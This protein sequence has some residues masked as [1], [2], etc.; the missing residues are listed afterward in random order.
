MPL[1]QEIANISD[2]SGVSVGVVDLTG[3]AF[4]NAGYRDRL[5]EARPDENTIYGMASLSKSFASGLMGLL[6]EENR[7]QFDTPIK[8]VLPGFQRGERDPAINTTIEDLLSHRS[9]LPG[10][11]GY[12]LLSRNVVAFKRH[13]VLPI[14][15]SLPAVAAPRTEFIYNNFGYELVGQAIEKL[16]G[17]R[18]SEYMTRLTHPLG[19]TRTFDTRIPDDIDNVAVPYGSLLNGR[20]HEHPIPLERPDGLF[21]A[22]GGMRSSV[23]DLLRFYRA[24]MEAGV[25]QLSPKSGVVSSLR[26]P[27]KQLDHIWKAMISLPYPAL[28][29]HSYA[30]GW[31]RAEL[32]A[33]LGVEG[34]AAWKPL[35]GKGLHSQLV[36]YHQGIIPGYTSFVALLPEKQ[37]AVVVLANSQGL[38]DGTALIGSAVIESLLGKPASDLHHYAEAARAAY[39][40]ASTRLADTFKRLEKRRSTTTPTR[41][42]KAYVGRYWNDQ[43]S[44]FIDI[45]RRHGS[46]QVSFMG[47]PDDTFE[48]LPYST[49]TFYWKLTHDEAISRG[50]LTDFPDDYY[51]I[52]FDGDEPVLSWRY[53]SCF[54]GVF[55]K[56][57]SALELRSLR[58]LMTQR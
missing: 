46:L 54:P 5:S 3:M 37:S 13:S 16:S 12:W 51:L 11:D 14:I 43:R 4:G 45:R 20:F 10:A 58:R 48:L 24:M 30:L 32:P 6:V 8:D 40:E 34:P 17:S 18:F 52:G 47:G 31:I 33:V 55:R 41:P 38:N 2:L 22:A 9:G 50:R 1:V 35:V 28:R 42:L 19:M 49:D 27:V 15:N 26:N 39:D 21:S 36:L 56:R 7:V 53:D 57:D 44:Y 29:E 25:S 23:K